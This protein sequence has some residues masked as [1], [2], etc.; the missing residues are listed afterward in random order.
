MA[1]ESAIISKRETCGLGKYLVLRVPELARDV[2]NKKPQLLWG[3]PSERMVTLLET[4]SLLTSF[5]PF[6]V[7]ATNPG[8]ENAKADLK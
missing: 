6:Q 5:L 1:F 8:L 2:A 4:Q 7:S 3:I